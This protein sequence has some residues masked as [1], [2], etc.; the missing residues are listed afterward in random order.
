MNVTIKSKNYDMTP[1]TEVLV[2]KKLEAI[3]RLVPDDAEA[4]AEVE[5]E[6]VEERKNGNGVY[7]AEVNLTIGGDL[8]RSESTRRS[9]QNA[10]NDV[11]QELQKELRRKKDKQGS[12]VKRGG[13]FAKN[14]LRG[15]GR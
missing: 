1:D 11:K 10:L 8:Y 2:T 12:F 9:L 7:R 5:V 14:I 3:D 6:L 4:L 13:R 15:F